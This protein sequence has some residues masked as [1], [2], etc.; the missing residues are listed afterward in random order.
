MIVSLFKLLLRLLLV[1]SATMPDAHT[2]ARVIVSS[3]LQDTLVYSIP[4][5]LVGQIS[6]GNRVLVPMRKRT[7]TGVVWE[8]LSQ[9]PI[10]GAKPIIASLDERPILDEQ[11][12]KLSRWISQYYL[13]TLGEVIAA[14]LPPNS[15]RESK[16][17]VVLKSVV[18][19][20]EDEL[21]HKIIAELLQRK[22]KLAA[23][24]LARK[25]SG[26]NVERVLARLELLKV[27]RIEEHFARS[28]RKHDRFFDTTDTPGS[29]P[30]VFSLTDEQHVALQAITDRINSGGFETFLTFGVTGSG[31]T[32]VYLRAMEQVRDRGRRCLILIPEISLTPQLLDRLNGRF[33]G[34]VGVLHSGLTAAERWAQWWRIARGAVDVVVGARS[35]V[36]APVPQLGLIVVDEEHD[37]SYKQE[38]GLH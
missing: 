17:V 5:P 8:I 18:G 3:P 35:A 34:R 1:T 2:F 32:E 26:Q 15:H 38:E 6:A 19:E 24:F 13:A 30:S 16:R 23:K 14:I 9:S 20:V 28:G 36:F 22:G 4:T 21:S 25:F 10:T 27:I 11:L 37:A 12:L 31:K 33:P 7:V 29:N